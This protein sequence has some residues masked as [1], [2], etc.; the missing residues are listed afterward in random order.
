MLKDKKVVI[1]GDRDGAPGPA[2][3]ECV[4]TASAEAVKEVVD[5][6]VYDEQ[7]GMMEMG[8]PVEEIAAEMVQFR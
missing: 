1:L 7:V 4:K 5:P 2:I 8:F 3:E 6:E